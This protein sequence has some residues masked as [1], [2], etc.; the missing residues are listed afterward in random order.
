MTMSMMKDLDL[1]TLE[2]ED[3]NDVEEVHCKNQESAQVGLYNLAGGFSTMAVS[4]DSSNTK[5]G[6]CIDVQL[7]YFLYSY[8]KKGHNCCSVH[9]G[10]ASAKG[11]VVPKGCPRWNDAAV[12]NHDPSKIHDGGMPCASQ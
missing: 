1:M 11:N 9:L 10:D 3:D 6:F 2:L 12:W 7:P 5:K 4:N 8:I